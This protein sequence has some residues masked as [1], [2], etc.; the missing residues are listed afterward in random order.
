[1]FNLLYG[2]EGGWELP[3]SLPC[4][5]YCQIFPPDLNNISK[6]VLFLHQCFLLYTE[7]KCLKLILIL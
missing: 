6:I 4:I 3:E 7:E 2:P 1:M 5:K